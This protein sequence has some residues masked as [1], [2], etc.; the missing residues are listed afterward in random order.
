MRFGYELVW[1]DIYPP[2]SMVATGTSHACAVRSGALFC[3]GSNERGQLGTGVTGG[4][5]LTPQPVHGSTWANVQ[6][7]DASTCGL[8]VDGHVLCWGGNS[9]GELGQGDLVDRAS[10]TLVPLTSPAL[11]ISLASSH[12][13]AILLD[14]T[15]H[16][17]GS[18]FEGQLGLNDNYDAPPQPTP[19]Q[20][21][22][23]R[24]WQ[25]IS[26]G[27]GHT[28][29]IRGAGTLWCWGRNTV[30]QL[31]IGSP[32]P[33]QIRSPTQVNQ[34]QNWTCVEAGSFITCA[35]RSSGTGSCWGSNPV[36][37]AIPGQADPQLSPDA[38]LGGPG[39]FLALDTFI[40]HSCGLALDRH[41]WCWGR[42]E[43]GQ[44]GIGAYSISEPETTL[45]SQQW[46]SIA[47][48]RFYTCWMA[49]DD[50]VWCTGA[51][52]G[53]TL[54]MGDTLRRNTLSQITF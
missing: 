34:A 24:D 4:N 27:E 36:G 25:H 51:N 22:S 13:C 2:G 15:L 38:L 30:G 31:G 10:P 17:W 40:F 6:V 35:L 42:N 21:G 19:V 1:P 29:G 11:T 37:A 44:L 26:A 49:L 7:G 48:A 9:N 50:S 20:V 39:A 52:D 46:K 43:E 5:A 12:V 32:T 33:V 28:C 41:A 14:H 45:G 16:C 23:E 47:V 18:N 53:G 8:R 54:G 3:W